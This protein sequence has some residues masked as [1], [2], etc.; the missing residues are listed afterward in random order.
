VKSQ[1]GFILD[2]NLGWVAHKLAAGEFNLVGQR[3]C[4]HHD[5]LSVR[6]LLENLLDIASHIDVLEDLIALVKDK[7]LEI[8]EVKGLVFSQVEN[9]AWS[10]NDDMGRVRTLQHLLLF[11]K[12]LP[13]QD[14]F[15]SNVL[16]ELR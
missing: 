13:T 5:L 1:L 10:A 16:D 8:F 14:D 15:S 9:T 3:S 4:E 11:L 7:H 12:R 2:E 6:S